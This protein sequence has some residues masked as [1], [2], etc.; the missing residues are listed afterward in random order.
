MRILVVVFN[1]S[2]T[3]PKRAMRHMIKSMALAIRSRRQRHLQPFGLGDDSVRRK[4]AV[5]E[6]RM[7][8]PD[9]TKNGGTGTLKISGSNLID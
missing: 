9:D 2:G 1:V 4:T 3:R 7:G 8:N 6:G 5:Q